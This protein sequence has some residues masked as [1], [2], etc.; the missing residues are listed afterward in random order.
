VPLR[1]L[2]S[3]VDVGRLVA[4]ARTA[5][6]LTQTELA[7]T[8]DVDRTAI[9]KIESGR[10]GL[11]ALELAR[12]ADELGR[13][14]EYFVSAAPPAV[15]SRRAAEVESRAGLDEEVEALARDVN[16][17]LDLGALKGTSVEA[18]GVPADL[19]E[20]ERLA[21]DIRLRLD[22]PD[23]PLLQLDQ[24]V[25]QLGLFTASIEVSEDLPD[26]AYVALEEAG[27]ALINASRPAGRRR[28][29]LAHEFGHHV[30]ADE[31]ATDWDLAEPRDEREK[32]INAFAIHLLMPRSSVVRDW[33]A[34]G[35]PDEPR[36]AAIRLAQEYRMSWTAVCTQLQNL[37]L[38]DHVAAQALRD[39]PP[40]RAD[41]LEVGGAIVDE[42]IPPRVSP[43]LAQATIRAYRAHKISAD[44]AVE[45]L[46]GMI[47]L[48]DLPAPNEVPV[49]ALRGEL[50]Q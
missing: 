35:G 27:V 39:R 20:A 10:R 28:F 32:R 30:M 48:E 7:A 31:Y 37:G 9:A 47:D 3:W 1:S 34:Y 50:L 33:P 12:L 5:R 38:L 29:T 6:G 4:Q 2:E 49:E 43:Q 11:S 46:R 22:R 16:L 23:G 8:L 17:L 25:E 19:G 26:G 15:I 36:W 14:V 24:A 45:L 40:T 41:H 13:P 44:R 21:R 18:L 42:L